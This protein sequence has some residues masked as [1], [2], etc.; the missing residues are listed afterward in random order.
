LEEREREKERERERERERK[1][2]RERERRETRMS[3]IPSPN[4]SPEAALPARPVIR[5]ISR[6]VIL[7]V[8]YSEQKLQSA[9][10]DA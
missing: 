1:R 4:N 8:G 10:W 7:G 5:K 2:E 6:I 3:E 9:G